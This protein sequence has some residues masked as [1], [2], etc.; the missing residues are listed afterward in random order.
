MKCILI[1]EDSPEI[2]ENTTEILQI[3]GYAVKSAVDGNKVFQ[4]LCRCCLTLLVFF[5]F[6]TT[7]L[8][9]V[10]IGEALMTIEVEE[11]IRVRKAN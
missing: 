4:R 9:K 3:T 5:S 7:L 6:L 11:K 1:I 2:G 10:E 8:V